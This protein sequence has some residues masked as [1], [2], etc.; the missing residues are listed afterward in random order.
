MKL[1]EDSDR[2]NY[3]LL[4]KGSVVLD[5]GAYQGNFSLE[6]ARKYECQIIG[7]EPVRQF[8][9]F[10]T[11]ACKGIPQ[12]TLYNHGVGGA[13]RD[14]MFDVR[15]DSSSRFTDGQ[16]RPQEKVAIIDIVKLFD[17]VLRKGA[18]VDLLKL[19][20]EGMEWEVIDR[21]CQSGAIERVL[22]LQVQF[23]HVKG[24][25]LADARELLMK[26]HHMTYNKDWVFEGWELKR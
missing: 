16:D 22:N 24:Y 10:A 1:Y 20:I 5:C 11:E 25:E 13:T 7:F 9:E 26:T 4:N 21:L 8:F 12:I 18:T 19:N 6:M 14:V 23:H 17:I 2:Y 15:N 3:P